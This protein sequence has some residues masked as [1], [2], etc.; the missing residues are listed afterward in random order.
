MKHTL[1]CDCCNTT[2]NIY[3][4]KFEVGIERVK[5]CHSCVDYIGKVKSKYYVET[6]KG[7]DIYTKDGMYFPYWDCQYCFPT[8]QDCRNRIDSKMGIYFL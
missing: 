8:L 4:S 5:V 6:Y 7:N 1:K 3:N 2:L